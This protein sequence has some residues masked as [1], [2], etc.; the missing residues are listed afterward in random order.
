[1]SR[2]LP[3]ILRGDRGRPGISSYAQL[4]A[5]FAAYWA[6]T[7]WYL[8]SASGSDSNSGTSAVEALAT[9]DELTRRLAVAVPLL[10]RVTVHVAQGTYDGIL[11]FRAILS[12]VPFSVD[13]VG[14]PLLTVL[15]PV[16][17]YIDRVVLTKDG[18]LLTV[19]G[20]ADWT[21][22]VNRMVQIVGGPSDGAVAWI[23]Q[24][25]PKNGAGV[26]QGLAVARCS[27]FATMATNLGGTRVVPAAG[28][29]VALVILPAVKKISADVRGQ[30]PSLFANTYQDRLVL[31]KNLAVESVTLSGGRG[32]VVDACEIGNVEFLQARNTY[33]QS[34]VR[35]RIKGWTGLSA[36]EMCMADLQYCLIAGSLVSS[37]KLVDGRI[38]YSLF[39]GVYLILEQSLATDVGVFDVPAAVGAC[40]LLSQR[41]ARSGMNSVYGRDNAR[42][43][44]A[45]NTASVVV[46]SLNTVTGVV[47][48][49]RVGASVPYVLPYSSLPYL[50]GE[51]SFEATLVVPGVGH[52]AEVT[53]YVDV[54]VRPMP[55]ATQKMQAS[56]KTFAGAVGSLRIVYIDST[57][58]RIVSSSATDVSVVCGH[59]LPVGD[60]VTFRS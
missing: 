10:H 48:D 60:A 54:A 55:V 42:E 22:Y 52:L 32:L 29:S 18:A 25:N 49:I 5:Y 37:F 41:S 27:S 45:L 12:A 7:D 39:Q 38:L 15:G 59:V 2:W 6:V 19:T 11:A 24:A 1:M 30:L 14:T 51:Q 53:S 3:D 34:I 23:A 33:A 46:G 35:S 26:P 43:G 17:S 36:V 28:S 9:L 20:V 13:V 56:Y 40:Q 16:A 57:T 47:G 8:D 44:I 31:I 58:V 21:P 50:D 4:I